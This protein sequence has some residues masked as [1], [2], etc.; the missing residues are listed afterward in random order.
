MKKSRR[1][2]SIARTTRVS[3]ASSSLADASRPLSSASRRLACC[4]GRMISRL[5]SH[6]TTADSAT[7]TPIIGNSRVTNVS[8]M[9]ARWAST[10][11]DTAAPVPGG[12]PPASANVHVETPSPCMTSAAPASRAATT[13]SK[14]YGNAHDTMP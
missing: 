4:I 6:A 10:V 13:E 5:H 14:P 7:M 2:R 8:S 1:S 12:S 11:M 9:A 3:R